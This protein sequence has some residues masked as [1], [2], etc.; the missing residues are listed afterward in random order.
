ME[1]LEKTDSSRLPR[2]VFYMFERYPLSPHT[3]KYL[4]GHCAVVALLA[5]THCRIVMLTHSPCGLDE[6]QV[7]PKKNIAIKKYRHPKFISRRKDSQLQTRY[8]KTRHCENPVLPCKRSQILVTVVRPRREICRL[9]MFLNWR[10]S[11]RIFL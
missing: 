1:R 8:K 7:P 5:S 10:E 4:E 9:F 6:T 11:L 2:Y 3:P